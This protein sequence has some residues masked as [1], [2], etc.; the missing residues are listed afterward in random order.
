MKTP[1]TLRQI[2]S[3]IGAL[4][5]EGP[6][7]VP[8]PAL[9][10][11]ARRVT[12]G[13]VFF[14]LGTG[15]FAT[16]DAIPL[17]IERGA[18]AIV[19]EQ[20]GYLPYRATRIRVGNCRRALAAAAATLHGQPSQRMQ[21]LVVTGCT[22]RL[23]VAHVLHGLLA[24]TGIETG[25]ISRLG[26]R[27]H[28][29]VL[30]PSGHEFE[31]LDI[32]ER[33]ADFLREGCR[34]CIVEL[35]ATAIDHGALDTLE[36]DAVVVTQCDD[37]GPAPAVA[38]WESRLGFRCVPGGRRAGGCWRVVD[39]MAGRPSSDD[40]LFLRV[41]AGPSPAG[42]FRARCLRATPKGTRLEIESPSGRIAARLPLPGR[43]AAR[44]AL[45]A[46]A[47][48]LGLR[49]PHPAIAAALGRISPVPGQLEP[50]SDGHPVHVLVDAGGTVAEFEQCLQEARGVA[51]GRLL[52][53]FGCG[54]RHPPALRPSYGEAA[55]RWSDQVV[56][57]SD[58][59]GYES[60]EVIAAQVASGYL[61]CKG[62]PPRIV[63]DRETAITHLLRDARPGDCVLLVGKGVD[64]VQEI[65][66]CR[67]PFSD[68]AVARAA[69]AELPVGPGPA[70]AVSAR[71]ARPPE[72][73][74]PA[75]MTEVAA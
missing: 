48:A 61:R 27:F 24:A 55:A 25:L 59:P 30:P 8:V 62:A 60:P 26:G 43:R 3:R 64:A 52:V 36:L 49:I 15:E 73:V 69:L 10:Y 11:D 12:P 38:A 23:G 35:P 58:S 41:Q 44:A 57:T 54:H 14:A 68:R 45:A 47:I 63:P 71:P 19:S 2:V 70:P 33:L 6:L 22:T 75:E 13:A 18:A 37:S 7:D 74:Q 66:A 31:A 17:A 65:G 42:S 51:A 56:L 29:R 20:G 32:Q 72:V 1:L 67:S 5:V 34:T 39:P 16:A 40:G 9:A 50:V 4:A 53:L 46:S 21:V 28:E